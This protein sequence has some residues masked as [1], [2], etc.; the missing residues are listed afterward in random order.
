MLPAQKIAGIVAL[1]PAFFYEV[2]E[3][4]ILSDASMEAMQP[5]FDV[6]F[7]HYAVDRSLLNTS[8]TRAQHMTV[9]Q[10]ILRQNK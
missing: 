9:F 8:R 5:F 4:G 10:R 1:L 2:A 3:T 7:H 6:D